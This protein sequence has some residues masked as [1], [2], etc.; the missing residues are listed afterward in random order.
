[1]TQ[2]NQPDWNKMAEK[3][4]LWVPFIESVGEKMLSIADVQ[5]GSRVLDVASGTGEPA[6][7]LAKKMKGEIEITGTDAME[8][9][10]KVAQNKV[11]NLGL[12]NI[13]FTTMPAEKLEFEDNSFDHVIC[14]FGVML[15]QDSQ[16]GLNEMCRVLK[17][18]GRFV[19]AVWNTPETMPIMNWGYLAFKGK[20]D[21]EKLPAIE[22]LT[23][24]GGAG[25]LDAMLEKAGFSQHQICTEDLEYKF[26]SF[27]QYWELVDAS[28]VLKMQFDALGEDQ[29]PLIQNEMAEFAKDF[30]TTGG[31]LSVPHQYLLVSGKK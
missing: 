21:D 23:S 3:F 2:N 13:E 27:Q 18:G 20:I 5:A 29:K 11:K 15:F 12:N 1:M 19:I 9:M 25:V 6:I 26:E 17:P 22:K 28:D 8:G 30:E 24:L 4:D 10:V 14:R 31:Q 7:T 16:Q